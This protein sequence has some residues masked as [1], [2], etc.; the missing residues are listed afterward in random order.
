VVRYGKMKHKPEGIVPELKRQIK[1]LKLVAD[2]AHQTAQW[3]LDA[4]HRQAET[5]KQLRQTITEILE[6][7]TDK[8]PIAKKITEYDS[9]VDESWIIE[10]PDQ[11]EYSTFFDWVDSHLEGWRSIL[12]PIVNKES[13]NGQK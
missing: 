3:T 2:S 10:V 8:M 9:I 1:E 13:E 4:N 12:S 11:Y 5:I 7:L 6:G